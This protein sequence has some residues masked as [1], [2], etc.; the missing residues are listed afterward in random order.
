MKVTFLKNY[1]FS[2]NGID[3]IDAREGETLNLGD[4][5][6]HRFIKNGIATSNDKARDAEAKKAADAAAKAKKEADD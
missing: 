6:A 1:K 5:T 3:V 4:H 2:E